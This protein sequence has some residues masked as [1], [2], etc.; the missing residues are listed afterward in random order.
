MTEAKIRLYK[1]LVQMKR[2]TKEEFENITG[3]EY[4]T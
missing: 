4:D 2:L 3:Q 1:F